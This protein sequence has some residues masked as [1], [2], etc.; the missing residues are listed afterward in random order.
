MQVKAPIATAFCPDEESDDD[1]KLEVLNAQ[2]L[3]STCQSPVKKV[4]G[5]LQGARMLH[6]LQCRRVV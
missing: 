3:S 6:F 1:N 2:L 5:V 4:V